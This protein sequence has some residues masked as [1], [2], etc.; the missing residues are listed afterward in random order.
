[1]HERDLWARVNDQMTSGRHPC[2]WTAFQDCL[3][4]HKLTV[5][6]ADA[7]KRQQFYIQQAVCKSQ[8]ATVQQ[9]T[10]QMGV[11]NDNVRHLPALKDSHKAILMAKKGN[12][13][14]GTADLAAIM[15]ASVSTRWQNRYNLTHLTVPQST[16]ALLPDLEAIG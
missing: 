5:F 11:L 3:E 14:F 7:A 2:L 12:I 8:R 16:C 9:H 4:L 15:L 10:L 13:P 6:T 1:M